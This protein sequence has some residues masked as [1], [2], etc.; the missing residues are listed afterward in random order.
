M[1]RMPV[2]GAGAWGTALAIQAARAGNEVTLWVHSPE[3]ADRIAETR[4]SPRLP[5]VLLPHGISITSTFSS[6]DVM[7]LAIPTQ[8]LRAVTTAMPPLEATIVCCAK[9]I[10]VATGA[11]PLEVLATTRPGQKQAVLTGPNFAHEIAA[12]L[13]AVSIVAA[14]DG[15]VREQV[16]QAL[17]T[18]AFRLYGNDD[19]VGAQVGGAAKNVIAIAAGAA[20]GA[21][22]ERTH[23]PES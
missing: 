22:L 5:G 20:I 9:G 3:R 14:D 8:H 23:A 6:A 19:P 11:L 15:A 16:L 4:E 7:L 12:G 21:G 1:S 10:E 18:P 2:I 17:A 13:P